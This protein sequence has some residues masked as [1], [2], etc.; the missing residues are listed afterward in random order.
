MD[1]PIRHYVDVVTHWVICN[2]FILWF[3]RKYKMLSFIFSDNIGH[4]DTHCHFRK[5]QLLLWWQYRFTSV[6][7]R[8][9][10]WSHGDTYIFLGLSPFFLF[11]TFFSKFR[12]MEKNSQ[13]EIKKSDRTD[14]SHNA[15]E[16][17][18]KGILKKRLKTLGGDRFSP[19]HYKMV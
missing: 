9:E 19:N 16:D 5:W 17:F 15:Y 3:S 8:V 12:S 7:T 13:I 4:S 11:L 14:C 1:I 2:F 6:V 18:A 10:C